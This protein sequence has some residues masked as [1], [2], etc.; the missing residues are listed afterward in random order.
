MEPD[1]T[2]RR[3]LTG[4]YRPCGSPTRTVTFADAPA[5]GAHLEYEAAGVRFRALIYDVREVPMVGRVAYVVIPGQAVPQ[6]FLWDAA[7]PT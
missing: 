6:F 7:R 3:R 4:D 5:V 1:R 2:G